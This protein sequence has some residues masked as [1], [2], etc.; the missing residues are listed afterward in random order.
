MEKKIYIFSNVQACLDFS[1][2][3]TETNVQAF[4]F[5]HQHRLIS[6][7]STVYETKV[8][9]QQACSLEG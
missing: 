4:I 7:Q 8:A 6:S 1:S 5:T 9:Q 2:A 3:F